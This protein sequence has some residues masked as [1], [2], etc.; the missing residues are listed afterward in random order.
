MANELTLRVSLSL[1][2]SDTVLELLYGPK[3]RDVAG[4]KPLL[5]RQSVG[6]AAEEAIVVGDAGA[7][8]YFM[9]I[10]R[11]ATNYVELRSGS[12]VADLIRLLPGDVC[13]FRLASDATLYAQANTA[14]VELEYVI[15]PA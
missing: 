9:A 12:G 11:D 10:N 1:E 3:L 4:T 6:H 2:K 15:L 7:G 5:N 13:L 14:A 8:G